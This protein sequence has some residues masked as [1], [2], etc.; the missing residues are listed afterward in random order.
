[1]G[2]AYWVRLLSALLAPLG[3]LYCAVAA[4]RGLAYRRGWLASESAGVPVVVV[5]NLTVGGTGKTP[6]VLWLVAHLQECGLRPGVAMRGYRG[7]GDVA[8]R[9]VQPD[10][11]PLA[12]GDEPV[13]LAGRAGCPVMVGRDRVA[14]ARLLAREHG[15]DIV[16]T[17]DGLQHYRLRRDCEILVVDGMRGLGNGRCLPAGPL[18]EPAGRAGRADLVIVNAGDGA[19]DSAISTVGSAAMRMTLV[20]GDAVNLYHAGV[21]RSLDEFR[22]EPITAVAGIGNPDRFFAML[23]NLGL[24]AGTRAFPDHHG[25]TA[26]DLAGLPDGPVLMTEKD[27][28]KCRAWAGPEHW[29]VPV[30]ARPDAAFVAA[31]ERVVAAWRAGSKS[32]LP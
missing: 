23:R 29:Y 22:G 19:G 14:A 5:G 31:F 15:C 30:R 21:S 32:G 16:V 20:P 12:F 10:G 6:L 28:V 2:G 24:D 25:Y 4:L 8:P 3:W 26:S 9:L 11:D 27:A 18:R 7:S 17:D 13:L 1:M